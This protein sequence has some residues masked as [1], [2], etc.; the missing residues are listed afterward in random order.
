MESNVETQHAVETARGA[1]LKDAWDHDGS[2]SCYTRN[3][4]NAETAVM[5]Q[6]FKLDGSWSFQVS[7]LADTSKTK[8]NKTKRKNPPVGII[9]RGSEY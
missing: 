4:H 1:A 2:I 7:V 5:N 9:H 3:R 6:P 8:Q